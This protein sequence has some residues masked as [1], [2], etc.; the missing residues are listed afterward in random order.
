VED[1][2]IVTALNKIDILPDRKTVL[3]TL[4]EFER[5][6]PISA[7]SGEGIGTLLSVIEEEM[8]E[9][10]LSIEVKLPY[11]EGGLISIFHEHGIVEEMNH[12]D[13]YVEMKGRIPLRLFADF[14][15]YT[16]DASSVTEEL[17]PA[18]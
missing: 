10:L 9:R 7:L 13:S 8:Y 11:R 5:G 1:I 14:K 3:E 18:L 6:V 15:P 4:D 2:P 16:T 17:D 12:T